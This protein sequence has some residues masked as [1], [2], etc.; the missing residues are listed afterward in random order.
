[1][2]ITQHKRFVPYSTH[3]NCSFGA[4]SHTPISLFHNQLISKP[5]S[6]CYQE[7]TAH[8]QAF[9]WADVNALGAE[10]AT[11]NIDFDFHGRS[12]FCTS[13]FMEYHSFFIRNRFYCFRRAYLY[14]QTAAC[15]S[16]PVIGYFPPVIRRNFYRRINFYFWNLAKYL[17]ISGPSSI[18]TLSKQ[19]NNS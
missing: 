4:T 7:I 10:C 1:M 12:K 13:F 2:R 11:R 3:Q 18:P 5:V 8:T 6:V 17:S 14:T 15:A 19:S 16:I 9:S